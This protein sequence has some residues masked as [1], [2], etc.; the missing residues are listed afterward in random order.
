MEVEIQS[1]QD[2][3]VAGRVR[4][5]YVNRNDCSSDWENMTGVKKGDQVFAEYDLK[6]SCGKVSA[7]FRITPGNAKIMPGTWTN[8][9]GGRGKLQLTKKALPPLAEIPR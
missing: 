3:N 9:Y 2:V 5:S 1:L 8:A 6:G 4:V 7:V